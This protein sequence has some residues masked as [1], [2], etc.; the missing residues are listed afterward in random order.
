MRGYYGKK[1]YKGRSRAWSSPKKRNGR[2]IKAAFIVT[3]ALILL[4]VGASLLARHVD[5]FAEWYASSVYPIIVNT[6]GRLF[7]L[8]PFAAGEWLLYIAV[9]AALFLIV[10]AIVKIVRNPSE[11]KLYILRTVS[12][13]LCT[14]SVIMTLFTLN[15]GVNYFRD[16]FS[17]KSG[18]PTGE[19]YTAQE[20]ADLCVYLVQGANTYADRVNTNGEVLTAGEEDLAADC[21]KAMERLGGRYDS[22]AGFYPA[23][24]G[25]AFSEFM[26][27]T[28]ILGIYDPFTVEANY[29]MLSPY[30]ARPLTICH[31]LSHLKGFMREDEANFIAYL[32][33]RDSGND[34]LCYSA[35]TDALL[36][37][38]NAFRTVASDEVYAQL[39]SY[40]S[41]QVKAEF[42]ANNEFWKK[43]ETPVADIAEEVNNGYL[44]SQGQTDG[45]HSYGRFVDL[46]IYDYKMNIAVQS[47]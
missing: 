11:R 36:Y 30:F 43:Y 44:I 37:A 18:L 33:C 16:P 45:T 41:P 32:A 19:K 31:E 39:Y 24:K 38:L 4:S 14:A 7:G 17:E 15:C 21:I 8:F 42:A 6:V 3:A 23:A 46:M 2:G 1:R 35:Y 29:N 34:I 27:M 26:N 12:G 9:A 25:V 22:L 47:R 5:G 28:R 13:A 20:L 40:I 10:F